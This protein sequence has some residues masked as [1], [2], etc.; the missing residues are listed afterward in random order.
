MVV[1][2]ILLYKGKAKE[3]YSTDDKNKII[4]K[5][6]DDATAFNGLKKDVINAKGI[7]NNKISTLIYK[8]L[9]SNGIA[10]HWLETLNEREQLCEKVDIFPLE[11]IVRNRAT[12][13]LT[14]RLGVKEG[15]IFQEAIFEMSYK[16]DELGDPLINSAH[17]LALELASKEEL[18]VIKE[19]ALLINNLLQ[20][21]FA[22]IG[23]ILVDFK[24]E[25]GKNASGK[26]LLA[27]EISPD[28]VRLWEKETLEKFD[29]DRFRQDLGN[30]EE[31][32]EEVLSRL[33][34]LLDK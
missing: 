2:G 28:S 10:T 23:F 19:K 5:Y 24:I 20:E 27:D 11:V 18:K 7:Y 9:I 26:I 25:F 1:R 17:A 34:K 33:E 16:N 8:Y 32:Y 30:V 4:M 13:S 14:K 29:K 31:A 15:K 6:K 21:L 22:K 3:I 12:G